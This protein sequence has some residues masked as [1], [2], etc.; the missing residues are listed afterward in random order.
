MM[1]D[2]EFTNISNHCLQQFCINV[3]SN[4]IF[5]IIGPTGAGK[6]TLLNSLCGLQTYSGSITINGKNIE[7]I[8]VSMRK[9]GYLFQDMNLFPHM[10]VKANIYFA[11]KANKTNTRP[12][13]Q[14]LQTLLNELQIDHL[15]ER[16]PKNLS[17]GEKQ[18]VSLARAL[19]SDPEIL[20]LDEP[21]K[22]LDINSAQ[23]FRHYLLNVCKERNLT[24]IFVT[25]DHVEAMEIADRIGFMKDGT[26]QQTGHY[27]DL[28]FNPLNQEVQNFLG[29]PNLF[30][31]QS[32]KK[33]TDNI[34]VASCSETSITTVGLPSH[35]SKIAILAQ[36]VLL[37]NPDF[38]SSEPNQFNGVITKID[39][40]SYLTNVWLQYKKNIIHAQI[41][42]NK[43]AELQLKVGKIIKM[44][45]P[46][47]FLKYYVAD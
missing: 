47:Q 11:L 42:K 1:P 39:T 13:N 30:A 20:L 36:H 16:Y 40:Q 22:H 27:Q 10:S 2:I 9:I 8:P 37:E 31:I 38:N 3:H 26:L 19:A 17:G 6:T 24:T 12:L 25:H 43:E 44:I 32:I 46:L 4:E 41:S 28:L 7:D 34:K 18:R 35:T 5:V 45:L 14:G 23:H 21:F 15:K 29:N 33:L